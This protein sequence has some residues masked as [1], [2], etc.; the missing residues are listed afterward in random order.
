MADHDLSSIASLYIAGEWCP[1]DG[2]GRREI[3]NPADGS[4]VEAIGYGGRAEALAAAAAAQEAFPAWAGLPARARADLLLRASLLLQERA[5]RIGYLLALESGKRLPEAVAEVRFA[6]EYLRWF[7]EQ[8]RRPAGE[9]LRPESAQRRQLTLRQP[10][11]VAL[12]LTPWNFPV[13]IQARKIA[14]ALAAGCTVVSRPSEKAPL[15]V[16]ELFRCLHEAGLPPGVANLVHGP[17]AEITETLLQ[18]PAVRVVSFTGSTEVGRQ[19]M[20]Q[21]AERIVRPLLELGG[22]APFIVFADADLERAVEGAMLAKFRNNGQSCIAANRFFVEAPIFAEFVERFAARINAMRVGNPVQEPIPDLGPVIDEQRQHALA[23]LVEEAQAQGAR[24]VTEA[25][26][27]PSQGSFVAPALL[28]DLPVG[29]ALV[30]EEI[31]GPVALIFP[32]ETEE[33][34][35]ALANAGEMGLA[36]YFYT[37]QLERSW[38]VAEALEAG[39]IGLN[40]P[41]PSVAYAPM[42]GVKQ[43]GLGREG[44]HE[45]LD[46]FQEIKYLSCEW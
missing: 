16:I 40:S 24:V 12:C 29:S 27:V 37:R 22:N 41:L 8:V 32:F 5:E 42:G 4:L 2:G 14:A 1:P 31:F 9:L 26:T 6:V 38:R 15:A 11:G 28:V 18:H 25:V 10:C 35:I 13:S 33:E 45:G 20:R 17:A 36:A 46:E 34:V 7:A 44:S 43:S 23:R 3:R 30:Q 19:I 21:A 39:I